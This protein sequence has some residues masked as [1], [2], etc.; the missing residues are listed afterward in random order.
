MRRFENKTVIVTGAAGGMGA[1]EAKLFAEE[2]AKVLITDL[3]EEKLKGIAEAINSSGGRAAY[4]VHDV[5]SEDGWKIVIEKAVG[6]FGTIN[7]LVNNAG[8]SGPHTELEESTFSDYQK[9][10]QVNLDSQYL[11]MKAVLPYLKKNDGGAIVNISSIAGFVANPGMHPAYGASK[12]GSRLL[13]KVAA[14]QLAKMNIRVNSIHPGGILT[15]MVEGFLTAE[16][17]ERHIIPG[18]PLGRLGHPDEVAKAVL[19]LASD[20]ASYITGTELL[21]DG[22]FTAI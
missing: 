19:F 15:P 10:I 17:I 7:V 16:E 20:D 13:T 12:G 2:G 1:S 5:S 18:I 22:G 4:I 21:V 8:I 3:Q 14:V 9:I 6:E 11:G